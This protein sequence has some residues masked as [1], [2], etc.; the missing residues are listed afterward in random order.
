[1]NKQTFEKLFPIGSHL[2][3][4]PMP[5]MSELKHDMELLKKNGFNLI[6]LQEHWQLDEPQEGEYD[7]S[8]YE[9]LISHAAKLDLGVYVG[10]TCEQAPA[11]LYRK[12]PQCRM[13]GRD[14]RVVQYEAQITLPADGKP[15]PCFDHQGAAADMNRFLTAAVTTLGSYENVVVWNTWQEIGYWAEGM[16]GN[17][18]CF[19]D[20]TIQFFREW[21]KDRFADLDKLNNAWNTRYKNWNDI[22]PSRSM[23]AKGPFAVDLSWQFFM[24]NVQIARVLKTRAETICKADPLNRPVFA[25]KAG[26]AFAAGQDWAY[27]RCQDFLGSSAY[28]AWSVGHGWD[29]YQCGPAGTWDKHAAL[30]DELWNGIICKSD[31][32]RSANKKGCHSWL[33]EFQGG[34]VSIGLHKGRV[35]SAE[36]IRRWMIGAVWAGITGISYWI[37]RAE[38]SAGEPNGFSLLDSEG[39]TTDRLAEAGRIGRALN[40]HA[41]LFMPGTMAQASVG[42]IVDEE[43]YQT[44]SAMQVQGRLE[45]DLRG[46][47]RLLFDTG[48]PVDFVN[49]AHTDSASLA[50]Y[51][52]LILVFPLGLPEAHAHALVEYVKAGGNLIS[53]AAPGRIS[54]TGF[55]RRGELSPALRELFGVTQKSFTMVREPDNGMRWSPQARTWGEYVEETMLTGAGPLAKKSLRANLY[56]STFEVTSDA[57]PVLKYGKEVAGVVRKIGKGTGWLLGTFAGFSGTAYCSAESTACIRSILSSCK[58]TP[59]HKGKLLLRKRVIKNKEAWVFINPAKTSV[60]ETVPVKGWKKVSDLLGGKISKKASMVTLIVKPLDCAVIIVEK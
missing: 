15:G 10:F 21:L 55:C 1:M 40:T 46:W 19:C 27:A 39:D 30:F 16:V 56:L 14:G 43:N 17:S 25:H 28:P 52:A 23:S 3:R 22:A 44:L 32:L 2:C 58:I 53:E 41:D 33:A 7:F 45:Y 5:A 51:K 8:K 29:D 60:T 36:D 24:D 26:P 54:E 12:H 57:Q 4:E 34:P 20:N 6:K 47:H 38:I 18:V 49:L 59:E 13:V 42:L 9:E 37:S 48:I 11:W 35:P 50:V 31:F